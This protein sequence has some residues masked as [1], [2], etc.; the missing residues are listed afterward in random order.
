ML[1][2]IVMWRFKEEAEGRTKEE[3]MEMMRSRLM[4]LPPLI[5]C[6]RSFEVGK[7]IVHSEKSFDMC[8]VSDFDTKEDMLAYRAHPD[9][10]AVLQKMDVC[11]AQRVV[12]DYEY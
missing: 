7:D 2:H 1:K 5:S 4:A 6:I 11:V 3:N 10:V 12:I 9:H 8:L